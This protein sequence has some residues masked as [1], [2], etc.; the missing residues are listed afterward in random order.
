MKR[1]LKLWPFLM[2]F[3]SAWLNIDF[4]VIP[5]LRGREIFTG[6]NLFI[7][8]GI[9]GVCEITYWYWFLKWFGKFLISNKYIH[10]DIKFG[11]EIYIEIGAELKR[12]GY[13]DKITF[14]F[15][16]KY[17]RALKRKNWIAKLLK[18]G[19]YFTI[20]L[21][22]IAPWPFS[23]FIGIIFCRAASSRKALVAL[24]LGDVIKI[25]VEAGVWSLIFR[26]V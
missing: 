8:A 12:K 9:L 18:G 5:F 26:Y 15:V 4:I 25:G 22:G 21:A 23:R 13:I 3:V 16:N 11:Q 14:Y 17:N 20:F 6:L 1:W 19:G 24:I 7:I 2:F 10:E